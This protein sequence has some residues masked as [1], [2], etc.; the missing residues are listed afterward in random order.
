MCGI[1]GFV[2]KGEKSD[3]ERMTS[4]IEHRGPD[5]S[6]IVFEHGAALGFRRLAIVDLTPTGHQPMWNADKTVAIIF[7]GE[8]YNFQELRTEL[9]QKNE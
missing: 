5:D 6:G 1:A 3:L 7:N 9:Q 4:A 8:I 2:G